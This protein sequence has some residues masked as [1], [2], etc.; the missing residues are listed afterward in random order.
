VTLFHIPAVLLVSLTLAIGAQV[1][2]QLIVKEH[3]GTPRLLFGPRDSR[4]PEWPEQGD[5]QLYFRKHDVKDSRGRVVSGLGF[6]A[7]NVAR[8]VRI[9]VFTLVPAPGAPNIFLAENPAATRNLAM[10]LFD[11]VE[12]QVG[13]S[14]TIE[15]MKTLGVDP[16]SVTFETAKAGRHGVPTQSRLGRHW[17]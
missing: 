14:V 2:T 3:D 13:K 7:W 10:E 1:K 9:A 5:V 4:P 12:V 16:V 6:I 8:G 17:L 11:E 15:K